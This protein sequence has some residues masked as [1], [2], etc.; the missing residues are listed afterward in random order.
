MKK[1][2]QAAPLP[3]F[4]EKAHDPAPK[5]TP[6][7]S[8]SQSISRS[9]AVSFS[10]KR[11]KRS[12]LSFSLILPLTAVLLAYFLFTLYLDAKLSPQ[13]KELGLAEAQ[14]E[15]QQRINQEIL[16]LCE[17]GQLS[18]EGL[19]LAE[20][21][22]NGRITSLTVDTAVLNERRAV[23]VER[24]TQAIDKKRS[25]TLS[26]PAGSLTDSG[27]LSWL[28]LPIR[29]RY[30]PLGAVYGDIVTEFSDSGVNQTRYSVSAEVR[31]TILLL[32]PGENPTTEA[33][34]GFPLGEILVVGDVPRW[35]GATG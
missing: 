6:K 16:T 2:I 4:E 17:S 26:V 32:L 13:L 7:A 21:D 11:K 15:M 33:V 24:I 9:P 25:F 31:V 23:L 30:T 29:V 18:G 19:I 27:I 20:K 22:K 8:Q 34:V 28:S 12:F 14:R 3:Q 1:L 35:Y 10:S 5:S